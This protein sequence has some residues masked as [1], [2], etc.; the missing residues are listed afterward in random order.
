M[1]ITGT[2]LKNLRIKRNISGILT[3]NLFETRCNKCYTFH[4]LRKSNIQKI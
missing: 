2:I 4:V 1:N 3:K